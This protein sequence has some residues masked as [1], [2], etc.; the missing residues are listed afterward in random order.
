MSP[1]GKLRASP[2]FAPSQN[3]QGTLTRIVVRDVATGSVVN[4]IAVGSVTFVVPEFPGGKFEQAINVRL[5][6]GAR[7]IVALYCDSSKAGTADDCHVKTF[8][9]LTG[10]ALGDRKVKADIGFNVG[11]QGKTT[12]S[13]DGRFL[14]SLTPKYS[15][16][17]V[18]F[19]LS[20]TDIDT[21]RRLPEIN[22]EIRSRAG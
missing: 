7:G 2:E 14:I 9:P 19:V 1:D 12:L 13:P 6:F 10:K 11:D 16:K 8:D 21:G 3:G 20:V 22:S 18:T 17:T 4:S 15:G 5:G